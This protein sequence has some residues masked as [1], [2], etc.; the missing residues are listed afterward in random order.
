MKKF[1]LIILGILGFSFLSLYVLLFSSLGNSFVASY[2][3]SYVTKRGVAAFKLNQFSLTFNTINLIA[4]IDKNSK[5]TLNGSYDIFSNKIDVKYLVD[6]KDLSKLEKFT[7]TK[8]VGSLALVGLIKGDDKNAMV[9]GKSNIFDS[10]SVYDVKLENFEPKTINI[11]IDSA[12]IE[13][14]LNVVN[15]PEYA[16]GT[17]DID[18]NIK[19]TKTNNLDG[20]VHLEIV[21]MILNNQIVNKIA[22]VNL[23][24]IVKINGN[25]DTKLIPNKL[26]SKVN[27]NSNVAN[28]CLEHNIIDLKQNSIN[29]DYKISVN[30]LTDLSDFIT[31]KSKKGFE[32]KGVLKADK[33]HIT[34][35][36][37]SNIFQGNSQY[38][39]ILDD[40]KLQKLNIDVSN[41]KLDEVF[42]Y[43]GQP[44]YLSGLIDINAKIKNANIGFLEGSVITNIKKSKLNKNIVNKLY[45]LKLEKDVDVNIGIKSTLDKNSITS[46]VNL[47]SSLLNINAKKLYVNL[48]DHSIKTDYKINIP[49]LR[50]LHGLVDYKLNGNLNLQGSINGN[51]KT[52]S[53]KGKG[54]PFNG[55]IDFD[56]KLVNF[57]PS[58]I[59]L[60]LNNAK[61]EK[62]L[63]T[64]DQPIYAKGLVNINANVL[65]TSLKNLKGKVK[66]EILKGEVNNKV[67]NKI[68]E[69]KLK[70][71]V[72]FKGNTNTILKPNILISN[73]NL[74]TS[75]ANL[76]VSKMSVNLKD[77]S[78]KSDYEVSVSNLNNLYDLTNTKLRGKLKIIGEIKKNTDLYI[79]GKS[80]ILGG[81]LDYSLKNDDLRASLN[82]IQSKDLLYMLYYPII[83]D[84]VATSDITYNLKKEKGLI[85]TVLEKGKILPNTYTNTIKNLINFDLT[86]EIYTKSVLKSRINKKVVDSILD[87]NS[88]NT[89]IDIPRSRVDLNKRTINALVQTRLDDVEFDT[90]IQGSLDKPRV[91][92]Q[93][94]KLIKSTVKTKVFKKIEKKLLDNIKD[95]V[96]KDLL[97]GLFK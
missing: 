62:L 20:T 49:N 73:L 55:S 82:N 2:L 97:K 91:K 8:L 17:V 24:K 25:V 90:K 11:K 5:I 21:D 66:S 48:K 54:D 9:T 47:K 38:E 87:M 41:A 16:K 51:D 77:K 83:F 58:Q 56:A 64:F 3:E 57:E 18:V 13:Q 72:L 86:K 40:K 79:T 36:G 67:I 94:D 81:T 59:N 70:K 33:K 30:K 23:S 46:I 63:N 61:I 34:T 92:I 4:I 44:Q 37:N 74:N 95:D 1:L 96:V 65:N 19:D 71:K 52:L 27:L 53:I 7:T 84:S 50:N 10:N 76:N 68:F 60:Q 29:S 43:M 89:E 12:K 88:K 32:I 85:Q 31:T 6:I 78:L 22:G 26:I 35:L 80:K 93:T 45:K 15:Q 69:L 39:V 28:I 14:I 75:L 42:A